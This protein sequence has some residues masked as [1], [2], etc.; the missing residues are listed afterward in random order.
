MIESPFS[1]VE[2]LR[3][4]DHAINSFPLSASDG[5]CFDFALETL[6]LARLVLQVRGSSSAPMFSYVPG[7]FFQRTDDR[8][9]V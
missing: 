5:Q 7:R 9:F 8:P 4:L 3:H 6:I 1:T 2:V